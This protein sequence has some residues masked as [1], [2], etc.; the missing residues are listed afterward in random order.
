MKFAAIILSALATLIF[1]YQWYEGSMVPA[2]IAMI[3][4]GATLIH[5]IHDYVEDRI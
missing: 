5:D 2:W 4:S 3:W 1:A